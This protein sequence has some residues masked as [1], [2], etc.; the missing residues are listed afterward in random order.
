MRKIDTQKTRR[1][2]ED[3]LRKTADEKTLIVVTNLLDVEI[4]YFPTFGEIPT[5]EKKLVQFIESN[6][7]KVDNQGH[8]ELIEILPAR[9]TAYFIATP[10]GGD[11]WNRESRDFFTE[12]AARA[13]RELKYPPRSG[14][15]VEKISLNLLALRR[16]IKDTE[17]KGDHIHLEPDE[18]E[19]IKE[20]KSAI[21]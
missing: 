9:F 12:K 13:Y 3:A 1:R 8:N 19:V 16:L 7:G 11:E 21:Y 18:I 14:F 10:K 17:E 4:A 5:M 2:I 20:L 6:G 15:V